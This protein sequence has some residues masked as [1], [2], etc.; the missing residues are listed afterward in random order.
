MEKKYKINFRNLWTAFLLTALPIICVG[1][2]S[3]YP[4]SLRKPLILAAGVS[5]LAYVLFVRKK[6]N[7]TYISVMF[8][9]TFVYICISVFYSYD[10]KNTQDFALVYLF[11]TTLL[12]VDFSESFFSR[13]IRIISVFCIVIAFS[14]VI[15]IFI[16]DCMLTYFS[17]IVNPSH[18]A[19]VTL[20]IHNEIQYSHAFS[21]FA[22]EKA[23]AAYIMNV[24]IAVYFAKYFSGNKFKPHDVFFLILMIAALILTAKRTLFICPIIILAVFM[25]LSKIKGKFIKIFSIVLILGSAFIVLTAVIP[26]MSNLFDR[27]ISMDTTDILTGRGDLWHYSINM[28]LKNPLFGMGFGAF[29]KFAYDH[30]YL[31]QGEPW[32]Y[33]GHN[34][35]YEALGEMGIIGSILLMSALLLACVTTIYFIRYTSCSMEQRSQLMFSLYIQILS[36]I[37]CVTGNVLYYPQQIFMWYIAV[38]IT[39]QTVIRIKQTSPAFTSLHKGAYLH[40]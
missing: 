17:F 12:F 27:F 15:S 32:N 30:G 22:R 1:G 34:V 29:N 13:L 37:Y 24:G 3:A 28:F 18:N 21:G 38:S 19:E 4:N 2:V 7:L 40:E 16:E 8:L 10:T 33:Y 9:L 20:A 31:Y 23:E 5:C 11:A 6:M 35:Y 36:F 26:Q 25:L 14:I 39:I